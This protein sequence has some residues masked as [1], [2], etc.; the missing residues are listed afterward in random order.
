MKQAFWFLCAI[1]VPALIG[2]SLVSVAAQTSSPT[3]DPFTVQ[4]T[5]TAAAFTSK[6][7]DISADGRF[8]VF[9]SNGD[10]STQKTLDGRNNAD[11]NFEIFL[12]DYA[13]RRIFQIT[14]TRHVPNPASSPSP[15]PSPTPTPSPAPSPTPT[16][17]PTPA[18]PTQIRIEIVNQSPMISLTGTVSGGQRFYTIVFSS[19]AP[20]PG[21]FDGSLD[22]L[23]SDG[24]TEIWT[25]KLPAVT[26]VDLTLGAEIPFINLA[27]GAFDQVTDT[28]ASRLPTA[29]SSTTPPF[30]PDDNRDPA[31]SDNGNIIA[32]ISTRTQPGTSTN[33]ND[34]NPELFF[35]VVGS[36]AFTQATNTQDASPGIGL[37][38]QAS[39]S[40]SSDGSVV[41]FLSSGNLAGNN[42]DLNAEIYLAN[43]GGGSVSNVRQVTRTLNSNQG[44]TNVLSTGRRLS[45]NGALIVFESTATDPKSNAAPAGRILGLWVYT[46]ATDTF[47]EIGTRPPVSD[48][49]RFPMFTDYNSSLAPSSLVF[50]SFLNFRPDG[51]FPTSQAQASEGLNTDNSPEIYLTQ[52]PAS[53]SNT[54]T[55]LTNMPVFNAGSTQPIASETRK[56]IAFS[57]FGEELGGGNGDGSQEIYYLL[58]PQFTATSG[59][60]LSFF[61]GASNMPV[62][63]ATPLPSPTPTPTP[64]PSPTPG[65][66]FGLA[67]GQLGIIRSTVALAPSDVMLTGDPNTVASEILRSPALP[68]ELN[69]VSV[70]V[71]GAAAGLYFVSNT[72]KQINFVVPI[73]VP[74]GLATVVVANNDIAHR[75]L[76]QVLVGQPDIFTS[77]GDAGGRAFAMDATT[78]APEPFSVTQ[79]I[80]LVVT[81]VRFA[82]PAEITV[83]VG[84]TAI[85]AASIIAVGPNLKMA[86]FDSII[87][88]LPASLA[89]AGDVPIQVQFQRS[90]ITVSRPADT[91][92][93]ITIN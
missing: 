24:N 62:T 79:R 34:G 37:I 56:R 48:V 76:L 43:F 69:G 86:G 54:F 31:I 20:D 58:T 91:A 3:P 72:D 68:V 12:L 17:A 85:P 26:D 35:H 45:R 90:I 25:Y 33:N 16:P 4:I 30:F 82:A 13:Q 80:E 71:R 50:N 74:T 61:T 1:I 6:M 52:I 5:N 46:A 55:R 78:Q 44:N 38:F 64:T 49:G 22:G 21:N 60:V 47:T 59:A 19:N 39:P 63:A 93:R 23:A 8:V 88:D 53:S 84:T 89:G 66:P 41:A 70:S 28:G 32:F 81:G 36:E 65:Q 10:V 75:G 83:T 51:T 14:N 40:L 29:G 77:T 92:P 11:G 57:V 87:F 27:T 67:A 73:G 9:T 15:T 2:G 42:A 7:S 18:D